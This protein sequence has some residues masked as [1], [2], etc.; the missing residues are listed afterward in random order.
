MQSNSGWTATDML[1]VVRAFIEQYAHM[2]TPDGGGGL[3]FP[4]H[5]PCIIIDNLNACFNNNLKGHDKL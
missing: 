3:L 4:S 1:V 2:M 5:M